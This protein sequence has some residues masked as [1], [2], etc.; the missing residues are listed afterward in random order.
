MK[1]SLPDELNSEKYGSEPQ[2]T[3]LLPSRVVWALPCDAAE[4]PSGWF[5]EATSVATWSHG[6]SLTVTSRL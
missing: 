4:S 6:F 5:S 3:T 2:P 1:T